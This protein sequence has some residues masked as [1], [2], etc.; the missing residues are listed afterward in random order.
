MQKNLFRKW[1]INCALGELLG[2]GMAGA[3]A[4]ALNR[5]LGEPQTTA[6][7]LVVLLVM[8]VA[9]TVEG[10]S[11]AVFQWN[12]LKQIFPKMQLQNWWKWTVLI[13]VLGWGIGMLPSLFF[14]QPAATNTAEPAMWMIAMVAGG[15]GAA[16]GVL[17][18]LFQSI[19][20][21]KHTPNWKWWIAANMFAWSVA[22]LL[23]FI[24]ATW[25]SAAT[26][27][28]LI[29]LSAIISGCLAG[30]SLGVVTGF[31]LFKKILP[32]TQRTQP[33]SYAAV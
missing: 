29:I 22:M 18:G 17:F 26:P 10:T 1:I 32:N 2:I 15:G 25:P 28:S 13:A 33:A 24:G 21:K 3:I 6:Q 20:L 12:V 16:A 7:K 27:V 9:G 23:I 31:F 30:L 4:V 8:L 14:T 5:Y 19:E 11:I